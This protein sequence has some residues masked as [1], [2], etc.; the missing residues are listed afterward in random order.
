MPRGPSRYHSLRKARVIL[1]RMAPVVRFGIFSVGVSIFLDQAR[2]LL[3]DSQFTWGERRVMGAVALITFVGFGLA[4]WVA[5][6]LLR[7]AAEL[8]DVVVDGVEANERTAELIE[9][10][11]VPALN[12]LASALERAPSEPDS[13]RAAATVRRAIEAGRWGQAER[14]AE[15]F[16]RDF[17]GSPERTRLADE[18]AEARQREV[19]ELRRQLGA[20]RQADDAETAIDLRDALTEHLKGQALGDLDHDLVRWLFGLIQARAR[21]GGVDT[22]LAALAERA[23]DSFGD[24]TEG[25][26]LR[27]ALPKLRRSAGLCPRCGR[28][29]RGKADACPHCLAASSAPSS[30]SEVHS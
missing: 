15:T 10:H 2:P 5:G 9:R 18:L 24:T 1:G 28:P 30:E 25:A 29:H 22:A 8:I 19:D 17:P 6:H 3:S 14:L 7:T 23:A 26:S 11:M 12:R 20:A 16:A 4:A 21:A 13:S 27:A